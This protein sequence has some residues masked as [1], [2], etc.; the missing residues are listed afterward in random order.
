MCISNLYRF[1]FSL[2]MLL[3]VHPLIYRYLQ[4]LMPLNTGICAQRKWATLSRYTHQHCFLLP[5]HHAKPFKIILLTFL[6]Q[7]FLMARNY[8]ENGST[9]AVHSPEVAI[10]W[11]LKSANAC[12]PTAMELLISVRVAHTS[13]HPDRY[14]S[15]RCIQMIACQHVFV[16]TLS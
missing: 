4:I 13:R 9:V 10:E 6:S 8:I 14:T 16:C 2:F 12:Y 7:M 5:C 15:R 11:L 3:L 1:E